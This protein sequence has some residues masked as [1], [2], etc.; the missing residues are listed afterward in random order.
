MER[1]TSLPTG[2]I[3]P[4][5]SPRQSNASTNKKCRTGNGQWVCWPVGSW[6][7]EVGVVLLTSE[8]AAQVSPPLAAG[9]GWEGNWPLHATGP[10]LN[11]PPIA[12]PNNLHIL[13]SGPAGSWWRV[14]VFKTESISEDIRGSQGAKIY[15]SWNVKSFSLPSQGWFFRSCLY[16]TLYW[17]DLFD[18]Y[19]T[20]Y[21]VCNFSLLH[22]DKIAEVVLIV[23]KICY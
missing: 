17:C 11:T 7:G 21:F 8:P 2:R 22:D 15:Q 14:S 5:S 1:T 9:G 19:D 18:S 3:S 10:T 4:N 6:V 12:Q 23:T 13:G 16:W 20:Q